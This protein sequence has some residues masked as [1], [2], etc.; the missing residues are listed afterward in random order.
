MPLLHNESHEITRSNALKR[1][2]AK[3]IKQSTL[4]FK[5]SFSLESSFYLKWI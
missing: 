3:R 4:F 5:K 1:W 2:Q